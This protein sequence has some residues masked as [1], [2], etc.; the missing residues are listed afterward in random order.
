MVKAIIFDFDGVLV[1]SEES[2]F[3]ALKKSARTHGAHIS[4]SLFPMILGKTTRNFLNEILSDTNSEKI[5]FIIGTQKTNY[6]EKIEEFV[7]PVQITI[8]FIREYNGSTVFAVATMSEK[9]IVEKILSKFGISHKIKSITGQTDVVYPKPHPEVY[10]KAVQS[11]GLSANQCIAIE[12]TPL[13]AD[14]AIDAGLDCYVILNGFNKK[15]DFTGKNIKGFIKHKV[16]LE[17]LV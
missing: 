2:R 5:P 16:D 12:D 13:G 4:D 15:A 10:L 9:Y 14:S 17:S 8:E 11:I 1:L 3:N 7:K 6:K